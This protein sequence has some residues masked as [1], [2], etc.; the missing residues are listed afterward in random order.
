M[1]LFVV[2]C[3]H[4]T[5]P[6]EVREQIA[7]PEDTISSTLDAFRKRFPQAEAVLL[8]TCNRM[9]FYFAR[10]AQS[11]PRI[12]DVIEFIATHRQL[13]AEQFSSSLY[14]YEGTQAARHLFRVASSLDSM[15]LGESQIL[16]QTRQSLECARAAGTAGKTIASLFD[17]ALT[18]AKTIMNTTGLAAGKVSVGSAAVELAQQIFS[19]FD[20]KQVLM[21]G[22]GK[23]GQ[24]TLKHLLAMK[25]HKVQVTNRTDQRARDL[26]DSLDR[27]ADVPVEAVAYEQ[28]IDRLA[29]TDI[30]ITCTGASQPVLTKENFAAIP[31]KRKYRPLLLIDIALPR[32]VSPEVSEYDS[33]FLY[34]ID[35]LQSVTEE[36]L[37]KR[38]EA[39]TRS[40]ELVEAAVVHYF[41]ETSRR[42]AGPLIAALNQHIRSISEQELDWLRPKLQANDADTE[43]LVEQFVHRINQKLLHEPVRQLNEAAG[44]GALDIYAD[45]IRA[46]FNLDTDDT[47]EQGPSDST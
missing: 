21:V 37:A 29:E 7:F 10:A 18:T 1:R 39:V 45:V 35:D 16:G 34:N 8:S 22:A 30:V 26:A 42:D 24:I 25:P 44:A 14:T 11:P 32:N 46:L 17:R 36:F 13:A 12:Q 3:N 5:A 23:M 28:W 2:G 27:Q 33:V 15:V 41:A 40:Q 38:R 4:R 20:D 47:E 6:V 19:R 9:E 31:K 43:A